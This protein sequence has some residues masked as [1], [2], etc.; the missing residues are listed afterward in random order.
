MYA[1]FILPYLF[2]LIY[3]AYHALQCS[4][5]FGIAVHYLLF[6][7]VSLPL[8]V[9]LFLVFIMIDIS[10]NMYA[11][12]ILPYLFCLIYFAYHALQCSSVFG[13]AVHHLLFAFVSLSFPPFV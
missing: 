12:F 6:A 5:F 4:S 10:N 11:L 13:I 7:S 1:L 2:C 8:F 9:L 3:F